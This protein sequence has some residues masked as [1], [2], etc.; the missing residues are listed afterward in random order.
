M[1]GA[2]RQLKRA[3]SAPSGATTAPTG[4]LQL[5]HRPPKLRSQVDAQIE[6]SAWEC[7]APTLERNGTD[8]R[9][10]RQQQPAAQPW[11]EAPGQSEQ[12]QRRQA[13]GC[14]NSASRQSPAQLQQVSPRNRTSG[15]SR[16]GR[17]QGRWSRRRRSE[18]RRPRQHQFSQGPTG[19]SISRTGR[20]QRRGRRRDR[21]DHPQDRE[22]TPAG[23]PEGQRHR[24]AEPGGTPIQARG[25][26]APTVADQNGQ[27]PQV[28]DH[29][30]AQPRTRAAPA[31]PSAGAAEE[32]PAGQDAAN[33]ARD[34]ACSW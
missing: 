29:G 12:P 26:P 14:S 17:S 34:P 21:T 30:D 32:E 1:A 23:Q 22:A 15:P 24:Q 33:R 4:G 9:R 6:P 8:R 31:G 11:P 28:S 10:R 18:Q 13:A 25:Q 20:G 5:T 19:Y 7:E 27:H 3:G 16:Q 2:P